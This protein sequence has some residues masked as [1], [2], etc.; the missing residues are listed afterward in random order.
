MSA[1]NST[2][3]RRH[4]A[5]RARGGDTAPEAWNR[6]PGRIAPVRRTGEPLDQVRLEQGRRPRRPPPSQNTDRTR[7]S[8]SRASATSTGMWRRAAARPGSA[9][10]GLRAPRGDPRRVLARRPP[11]RAPRRRVRTRRDSR[12]SRAPRSPGPRGPAHRG[13]TAPR[14]VRSGSSARAVPI[15][16]RMASNPARRRC[17]SAAPPR[18]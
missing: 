8:P 3:A 1:P 14:T 9:R 6:R 7:S 18:R 4:P 16:T 15:P 2:T 10:P 17:A 13:T 12:G 11:R 5:S